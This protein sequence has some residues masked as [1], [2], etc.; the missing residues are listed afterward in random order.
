MVYGGGWAALDKVTGAILWTT[1]NPA[2][3]D[4][5]GDALNPASNGRAQT[6]WASGPMASVGDIVL[7]TSSDSVYSPSYSTGSP[8]YGSGGWVYALRKADGSIVTSYETKAGVYGGFSVDS[9]C[10]FVGSGYTFLSSGKGVYGWC[11]PK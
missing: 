6:S 10:A 8:Q 1:A 3:Y 4:P 11:L 9:H 7:A 5:T 2:N